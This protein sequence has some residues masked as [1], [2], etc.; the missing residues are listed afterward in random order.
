METL[1]HGL[2]FAE[3]VF[4]LLFCSLTI[5]HACMC[6]H[7]HKHT[8]THTMYA[9]TRERQRHRERAETQRETI[10]LPVIY[11]LYILLLPKDTYFR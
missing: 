8:H 5:P 7:A 2:P 4:F 9:H 1:R 3:S 10:A 6:E 11:V